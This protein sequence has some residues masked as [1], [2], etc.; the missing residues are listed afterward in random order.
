MT[1]FADT[2]ADPRDGLL[3]PCKPKIMQFK[4]V[5][6]LYRLLKKSHVRSSTDCAFK[7]K[8]SMISN[9]F[10]KLFQQNSSS[11]HTERRRIERRQTSRDKVSV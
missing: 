4:F 11:F 8:G 7:R 1:A 3:G 2:I 9:A 5:T 10:V 6:V